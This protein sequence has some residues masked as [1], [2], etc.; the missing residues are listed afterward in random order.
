MAI[1]IAAAVGVGNATRTID[2]VRDAVG[3]A[4]QERDL[5][6]VDSGEAVASGIGAMS[7]P[8]IKDFYDQMVKA[9]LYKAGEVDLSKVATLQ[10]VNKKI[11]Q[12]VKA[13]LG[14]K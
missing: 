11:G 12:D 10:F 8:R 9:G 6:I 5:G 1:G 4:G 3:H 14:A 7:A 13:R 2:H